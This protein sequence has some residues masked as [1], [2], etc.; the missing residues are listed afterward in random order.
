[1][2]DLTP[3]VKFKYREDV[4]GIFLVKPILFFIFA[5]ISL[6]AYKR[7]LPV[8]VTK[9]VGPKIAG[10]SVSDTHAEFRAIDLSVRG[11]GNQDIEELV[12][13]I[14]LKYSE[15][16]GAYS[17]SDGEPRLAVYHS[18]TDWHIHFQCRRGL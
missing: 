2:T 13:F 1:M 8:V 6:W 11:W 15:E 9:T 12:L 3:Y 7:G 5:D 18:G 4:L 14:N 16:F 17:Y 10:V